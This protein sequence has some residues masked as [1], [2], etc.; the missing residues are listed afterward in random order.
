MI[1]YEI[2][3]ATNKVISGPWGSNDLPVFSE[4]H[5]TIPV[6]A[7]D[8]KLG[9]IYSPSDLRLLPPNTLEHKPH[10]SWVWSDEDAC[11]EAPVPYPSST[12]EDLRSYEW[13][14]TTT[15]WEEIL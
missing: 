13:D 9:W 4:E 15:S 14:E 12:E 1:Y 3:K 8:L 11:W 10:P 7:M 5:D 2:D 6:P